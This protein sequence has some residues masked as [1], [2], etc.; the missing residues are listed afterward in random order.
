MASKIKNILVSQ[1]PP[2]NE[3]S[4]YLLLAKKYNLNIVFR[5]FFKVEGIASKDFRQ[6][7]VNLNDFTAV[8][9]TSKNAIDHYFRICGEMRIAVQD[10]LKYFCVSESIALYLQKYVVYRKRKIFHGKQHFSDLMEIV[11][12]HNT[13]KFLLPCS[14]IHKLDI[15]KLL[16]VNNIS[17]TKAIIY[18]T[19]SADLSDIDIRD[20]HM[21]VFFSPTGIKS[22]FLNYPNFKQKDT[23]IAAFGSA[24]HK[25][26]KQAGLT[27]NIEAPVA[28]AP[29]MTMAIEQ[30]LE[31][32]SKAK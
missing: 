2:E 26:V 6:D 15:P 21:L 7:K 25:A 28:K 1:P 14:D 30:Y 24:T 20:Y 18:R 29:S 11:K 23:V 12:K 19:M 4:P 9:F 3:K 8:I 5:K 13:E 16:D 10:T 22:L 31:K 32:L 27:L 17:Y